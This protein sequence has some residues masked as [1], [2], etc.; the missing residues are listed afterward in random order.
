MEKS[1]HALAY[2]PEVFKADKE[3]ATMAV[4]ADWQAMGMI[5]TIAITST[6]T[7]TSSI[8]TSSN[9]IIIMIIMIII[10]KIQ[11]MIVII[12]ILGDG[13]H[14]GDPPL[15]PRRHADGHRAERAGPAPRGGTGPGH[16]GHR[17]RGG[18]G[19]ERDKW[20]QHL[21]S[22]KCQGIPFSPMS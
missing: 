8:M 6:S 4:K 3:I 2:L 17:P 7:S 21:S 5:L 20:G 10:R 13:A 11:I 1:W 12:I 9:T 16:P 19:S 22:Q 14:L 15:G 18:E